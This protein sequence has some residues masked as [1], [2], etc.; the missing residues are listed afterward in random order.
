MSQALQKTLSKPVSIE[1]TGLHSGKPVS[2]SLKPADANSGFHFKRTDI[3]N[4][5]PLSADISKIQGTERATTIQQNEIQIQ[6][7]EHLLSALVGMDLDNVLIEMDSSEPPIGDG[8]AKSFIELIKKAG[9]KT[10]EETKK[11]YQVREPIYI[12]KGNSFITVFPSDKFEISVTAVDEKNSIT[13]YHSTEITPEIYEKEIAPARTFASFSDIEELSKKNLI[14]G[15][16]VENAI[17]I[18]E[19]TSFSKEPLRFSNELARHKMLDIIGDLALFQRRILGHIIAI[20]PGHS[21]N[22]MLSNH[23]NKD[24]LETLSMIPK[25]IIPKGENILETKDILKLIPHRYPFLLIDRIISLEAGR[26]CTAIKNVSMNEPFFQGHFPNL[27]IMPGVLQIEAMAQAS[28]ILAFGINADKIGYFMSADKVKFRHPV[29]PG[30][31][32]VIEAKLLKQR[33]NIILAS[34]QCLVNEKIVS[35]AE[36]MF[37]MMDK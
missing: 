3:S 23:L 7:I 11:F 26:K 20:N 6:T 9:I 2:L 34:C 33:R 37:S 19:G 13:Q 10:Q 35:S 31:T 28:S 21:I 29:T 30:D 1:G 4:S 12:Q 27:P 24:Y 22:A 16:S 36:A 25:P 15:A 32:L 18:K 17:L 14:K 8:S 5:K